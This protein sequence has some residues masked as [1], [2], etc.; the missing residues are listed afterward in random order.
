[1]TADRAPWRVLALPP[2]PLE[3][4]QALFPDDR[5]EIVVPP[6]RT[7]AAVDALLPDVDVV[8]GDWSHSLH[9]YDPG[10]RLAF[11][12]MPSVGFDTIDVGACAAAGVP[13]ANAAGANATSV[14]EWC[15]SATL[16]LLRKTVEAD[17]AVRRGEWP[18][19]T[20]GGRELAGSRVGIV[21]MGSI[22]QALAR[23]YGAFGCTVRYWSR[24]RHDDAPAEYAE[25][26]DLLAASDVLAL[27]VAL[28]PETRHLI[29]ARRLALMPPGA[30]LVNGSRGPVVDEAALAHALRQGQL[31]GAA[32]DVFETEPLPT[33]SPLRDLG[34]VLLS[35]HMAGSSAQAALRIVAQAKENLTRA[36]DGE[37]VVDVV[38]GADPVVRRRAGGATG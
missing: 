18:Q 17:A 5:A 34:G 29:D 24:S 32:L 3:V 14:A 10:P 20:L 11:V 22:G 6:E 1:M 26:D 8:L 23:L 7:Q 2:L 33:D 4:L 37:P 30:L 28:A 31:G 9:V 15:L 27:V 38:N 36:F 25:L 13:V 19:T 16:A 12:Q 21:G 35:P